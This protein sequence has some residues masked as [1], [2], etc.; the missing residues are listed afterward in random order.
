[1]SLSGYV[2]SSVSQVPGREWMGGISYLG[3][4]A[5]TAQEA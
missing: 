1:M 2:L 5:G 4:T 3:V